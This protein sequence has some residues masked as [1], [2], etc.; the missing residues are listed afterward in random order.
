MRGLDRFQPVLMNVRKLVRVERSSAVGKRTG[1]L[2]VFMAVTDENDLRTL[3]GVRPSV[4]LGSP[5]WSAPSL[6]ERTAAWIAT[7]KST[8]GH[9]TIRTGTAL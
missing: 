5:Q 2:S 4:P 7:A 3:P 8:K 1:C 6:D 9:Y